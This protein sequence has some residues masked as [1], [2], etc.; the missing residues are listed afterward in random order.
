LIDLIP[1]VPE[2]QI[3]CRSPPIIK[4]DSSDEEVNKKIA[5]KSI[6]LGR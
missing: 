2:G 4:L 5:E 6:V 3:A 1:D